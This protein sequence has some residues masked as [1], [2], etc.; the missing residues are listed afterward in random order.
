[1]QSDGKKKPESVMGLLFGPLFQAD[2]SKRNDQMKPQIK[3]QQP[4]PPVTLMS[5]DVDSEDD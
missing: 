5:E 3:S 2:G 1:M 4:P